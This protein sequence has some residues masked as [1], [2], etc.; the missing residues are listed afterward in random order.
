M[1]KPT[2]SEEPEVGFCKESKWVKFWRMDGQRASCGH[3][4]CVS[5]GDMSNLSSLHLLK[6][7]KYNILPKKPMSRGRYCPRAGVVNVVR[8]QSAGGGGRSREGRTHSVLGGIGRSD[9]QT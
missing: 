6:T 7:K 2:E 9:F 4:H 3:L 5:S 8:A 1:K